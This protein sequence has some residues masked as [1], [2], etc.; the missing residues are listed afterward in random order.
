VVGEHALTEGLFPEFRGWRFLARGGSGVVYQVE[1]LFLRRTMALKV[2][3]RVAVPSAATAARFEREARIVGSLEHPA[4]VRVFDAGNRQGVWYLAMEYLEG[5]DLA[6]LARAAG[7]V[8]VAD[9]CELVRQAAAAMHHAHQKGLVHRDLK[10]GNLMLAR[11]AGGAPTV[12]V[13][14][15]GLA[16]MASAEGFAGD[17]TGSGEFLGTVDYVAPEQVE[18]PRSVGAGADIYSLGAT[19][20][21]LLAGV[22]P[23]QGVGADTTIYSKLVRIGREAAPAIGLRRG[24]LPPAL[25]RLVDRMV[26]RDPARRPPSAEAVARELAPFARG[27]DPA[28]LLRRAEEQMRGSAA[29][30]STR[31]GGFRAGRAGLPKGRVPVWAVGLLAVVVVAAA[32]LWI[33][34][35]RSGGAGVG[36]LAREGVPPGV[37]EATLKRLEMPAE[38]APRFLRSGWEYYRCLRY[39]P[40]RGARFQPGSRDIYFCCGQESSH[41]IR[42]FE[43][44]GKFD[45]VATNLSAFRAAL[46]PDRQTLVWADR[47]AGAVGAMNLASKGLL[48]RL[49]YA[50]REAGAVPSAIAFPPVRWE[51]EARFGVRRGLLV[52]MGAESTRGLW[53]LD[54]DRGEAA[55]WEAASAQLGEAVDLVFTRRDV[56]VLDRGGGSGGGA[57]AADLGHRILRLEGDKLTPCATD[58]PVVD[59]C[60]IA[61]DPRSNDLYVICGHRAG[62]R[63]E[64][65]CI[66]RLQPGAPGAPFHVTRLIDRLQIPSEGGI[67][68]SDDGF[69]LVITDRHDDDTVMLWNLRRDSAEGGLAP[70]EKRWE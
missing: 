3:H 13:L 45:L 38:L 7:P 58:A 41:T 53:S 30:P 18:D 26:D 23:H 9:V 47:A 65:R 4:F 48:P 36:E 62:G 61:W 32:G 46:C 12:R 8:A 63:P 54:L 15:F 21:W 33:E 44:L 42:R 67:D 19:L 69:E 59:P 50:G 6:H 64:S 66:L 14:D 16:S 29:E 49:A 40:L 68:I 10:P 34:T 37:P 22:A 11:N 56:Y 55:R 70:A 52:D 5:V 20:Y 28:A 39:G 51:G 57:T 24:D 43:A 60:G 27:A 1:H 2:L 17:L 25:G 31:V 35:H